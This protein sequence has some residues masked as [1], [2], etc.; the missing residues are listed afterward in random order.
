MQ[1]AL[2]A[3]ERLHQFGFAIGVSPSKLAVECE[4]GYCGCSFIY[5]HKTASV[6]TIFLLN[7]PRVS[8]FF[9]SQSESF[10]IGAAFA[11]GKNYQ[12]NKL[13]VLPNSITESHHFEASS[14]SWVITI[15]TVFDFFNPWSNR[16][17]CSI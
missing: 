12:V 1:I 10:T 3:F 7:Q 5:C 11:E 4:T 9:G 16:P 6:S 13:E 17:N 14:S 15:I 2:P 8:F